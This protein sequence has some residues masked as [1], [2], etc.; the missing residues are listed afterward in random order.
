MTSCSGVR[1]VFSILNESL[2]QKR[3]S[4]KDILALID[5]LSRFI[6]L[7]LIIY[8]GFDELQHFLLILFIAQINPPIIFQSA[9]PGERRDE[10][11]LL[12]RI[13]A[14]EF[15]PGLLLLYS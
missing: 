6:G 12:V 2:L 3:R 4:L 9:R 14:P 11:S 13:K 10:H 15:R 5:R 7:R 1:G 8:F